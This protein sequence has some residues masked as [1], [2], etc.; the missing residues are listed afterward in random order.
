MLG[1]VNSRWLTGTPSVFE[2]IIS[3]TVLSLDYHGFVLVRSREGRSSSLYHE[4]IHPPENIDCAVCDKPFIGTL[5]S[6]Y[7]SPKCKS[8]ARNK[9]RKALP[10]AGRGVRAAALL[11]EIG[12]ARE[13]FPDEESLAALAGVAPVTRASGKARSVGFR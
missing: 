12:D 9:R 7:C 10:K 4:H 3:G 6:L 1:H 11:A 5:K 13:R 2:E 8:R